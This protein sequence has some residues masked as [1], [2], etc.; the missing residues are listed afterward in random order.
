MDS[1]GDLT[2]KGIEFYNQGNYDKALEY[3]IRALN[4]APGNNVC[5]SNIGN[6][7]FQ[8]QEYDKAISYFRRAVELNQSD[9]ISFHQLGNCYLQKKDFHNALK[10]FNDILKIEP[11]AQTFNYIGSCHFS[12]GS[13]DKAVEFFRKAV[14]L[15]PGMKAY[16]DN[17]QVTMKES[18]AFGKLSPDKVNKVIELNKLGLSHQNKREYEESISYFKKALKISPQN[19]NLMFNIGTSYYRLKKFDQAVK[20][21]QL[22]IKTDPGEASF[23][24]ALGNAWLETGNQDKAVLSYSKALEI[25]PDVPIANKSLGYIYFSGKE[26]EKA[27][28]CYENAV[29]IDPQDHNSFNN[30]AYCYWKLEEFKDALR[31]FKTACDLEPGNKTYQ[32]NY[33]TA[34]KEFGYQQPEAEELKETPETIFNEFDS[35]IGLDNI[36]EE[37]RILKEFARIEK[38]RRGFN[39]SDTPVSFHSVFYGSPGTG[40]TTVAR[41]M[42]RIFK[43]LDLIES[44]HVIEVSRSDLIAGYTGQTAEKTDKVIKE[45]LG[46]IL[47]ID[48]AYS[49]YQPDVQSDFGM[50]AINTL[51][52][53]M[54]DYR[55][56]LIVIAAGYQNEMNSFL[57][58]NPGLQ[59]RFKHFFHFKD[60]TSDELLAV[61][62]KLCQDH[63]FQLNPDAEK[64]LSQYFSYAYSNRDKSFANG[65]FVRNIFEEIIKTQSCRLSGQS[66]F[67]PEILGTITL[68]DIKNTLKQE[69]IILGKEETDAILNELQQLIGLK[70]VKEEVQRLVNFVNIE[71]ERLSKGFAKYPVSLHFV[72]KG[73]PGTGKTTVARLLGKILMAMGILKKGHVHEVT[74]SDLVGEFI[75]NTAVKTNKQVDLALDGILF[76]DEAYTLI[77]GSGGNDYG[78][79]ALDTIL[80]RMEDNRSR[81]IVIVAGYPDLMDDFLQTNPGLMSRFNRQITFHDYSLDELMMIFKNFCIS[82]NYNILSDADN[83]IKEFFEHNLQKKD[84]TFGNGRFIRNVFEEIIK[85]MSQRISPEKIKTNELLTTITLEDVNAV[86]AVKSAGR[87]EVALE[88]ILSEIRQLT[89]L[90][91][92]KKDI[93]SLINF[94]NIERL[95]SKG[96]LLPTS[97]MSLHSVFLGPPGTGKTTVARIMGKLFRSMGILVLGHVIEADRSD[98][99]GEYVGHTAV[100]TNKVIDSAIDGI[101]FI[102]EAYSLNPPNKGND[103]GQEAIATLVKRMEDDRD[104]LVVIV[105]GYENEMND[106][107]RSNPGLR[108]RFTRSF[109]F[110]K[111]NGD[112]LYAIFLK[113]CSPGHYFLH[114]EAGMLIKDWFNKIY[115]MN[116]PDMGNGRFVRNFFEKILQSQ[117][118]RLAKKENLTEEDLFVLMP[119]DVMNTIEVL[120]VKPESRKSIGY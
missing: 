102:D 14:E 92:I 69:F 53:R 106:F 85:S 38:I 8:K 34:A 101:L 119:E 48:E 65:R 82:G 36:K 105:A 1:L 35:L 28:V 9:M 98:L 107:I 32:N 109:T 87:D 115:A 68:E 6:C 58:A 22:A 110:N 83:A 64:G 70:E 45:A 60:Y 111:Y 11:S 72:F 7:Y 21:Y 94:I 2:N 41:L 37:I 80:K 104:R 57:S 29:R 81:L 25:N 71:K 46:G 78:R 15:D 103:F 89:G 4:L 30:L 63:H 43:S 95:R 17:L 88:V 44:G 13:Y 112:E 99:V 56:N 120:L 10:V 117:A 84:K 33:Q 114:E 86:V 40:K 27:K 75:G 76:I 73:P 108:S 116:L 24:A 93:L 18:K 59:S 42:G 54:E 61:F 23:H 39:L 47:F 20:Y 66:E 55:K 50:E 51:V 113:F 118:D 49:L 12:L 19:A 77:S 96:S 5:H 3:F 16:N 67:T 31:Y 91:N 62:L 90:E 52:K 74:R 97:T 100:K 79:E 26:Y